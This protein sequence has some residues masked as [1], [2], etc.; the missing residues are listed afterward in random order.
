MPAYLSDLAGNDPA[1]HRSDPRAVIRIVRNSLHHDPEGVPLP[2][3]THIADLLDEFPNALPGLVA[4]ARLTLDEAHPYRGYRN[5]TDLL[6][7]FRDLADAIA[8]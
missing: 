8:E 2:G 6:R 5:Y 3:A 7:T 1:A 4:A